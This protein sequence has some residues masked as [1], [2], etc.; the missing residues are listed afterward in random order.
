[1]KRECPVSCQSCEYLT[2]QGRCPIDPNAPNAW[3]PGDLDRMFQRLTSE[4]FRSQYS[5]E[6]LS[7]DPWVITMEDVVSTEE[8]QR[9]IQL[10]GLEGYQQSHEV[11][12]LKAD[13]TYKEDFNAVRRT[14]TNAW[15]QNACY[16]D[17][18][19]QRV[20]QR[21]SHITGIEEANSEYLQLLRYTEGQS[22]T[23]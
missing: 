4:P 10:G 20:V 8:A 5:V 7:T 18:L 19:A 6:I 22:Y 1:M 15:C 12:E 21:L 3:G 2:I 14:S 17:A 13:G 16:E 23:V 9:L 11:G